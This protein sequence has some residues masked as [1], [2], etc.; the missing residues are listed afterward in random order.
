[1]A[2]PLRRLGLIGDIHAE[3]AKLRVALAALGR[4]RLDGVLAVG[5][6][7]DGQGSVVEC[8]R[9]LRGA[10]ATVVR[11][12][13]DRWLLAGQLRDLPHATALDGLDA[14]TTAFLSSLP[15]TRRL[16]TALGPLLLCHGMGENDMS[17]VGEDDF[18][19]ALETNDVLQRLLA[20]KDVAIVVSGHR[21]RPMVRKV[22]GL[23]RRFEHARTEPIMNETSYLIPVYAAYAT[24]TVSLVV[25]LARTLFTN[26][27]VF[28]ESVFEDEPK[29]ADAVNR[30]LVVGFYLFNLGYAA[31]IMKAENGATV[32]QAIEVLAWKLGALLLSLGVMHFT[33]LYIFYRI[34]R[35]A[36]LAHLPPPVVPQMRAPAYAPAA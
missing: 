9:L 34:R 7:A 14:E 8:C 30:L 23:R 3:D 20:A 6:I 18:G 16:D 19:Y 25:W 2:Q 33:N 35:R 15:A 13:H 26:G 27:A 11:G 24:I 36:R 28:L 4:E 22:E 21:H 1:M 12:N 5:D 29:M 17:S 31:L 32:I 10:G